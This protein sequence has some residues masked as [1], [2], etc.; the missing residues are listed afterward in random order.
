LFS[1]RQPN[2]N[3]QN[4]RVRE[5]IHAMMN[6]WLEKGISGFRMDVI[7]LIGKVPDEEITANG[8]DLHR[9]LQ[10][11]HEASF[12]NYDIMT[13]GETWGVTPETAR[14]Y[15]DPGRKEL[16]MVF[17]FEHICLTWDPEEGKWR[18]RALDF[19]ALKKSFARWQTVLHGH[20]WNSLFWN[21]HDLPRA[22]SKYGDEGP[23]RVVSAKML[24]TV[25]HGMQGTPYIFQG[26]EI[27]MTNARFEDLAE[28]RDI[29]T[30][31]FYREK[32]EMGHP[33][34][35][36]MKVIQEH[37]RDNAR[38]PMQW[39]AEA[40]AGFTTGEPW[41]PVNRNYTEINVAAALADE[42]SIYHYYKALISLRRHNPVLVHGQFELL[43]PDHPEVFA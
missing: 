39:S 36:L 5:E 22:V 14:L 11:M 24:A 7:D 28:Y 17:Q 43:E 29:E 8:P 23:V 32:S 18:P 2:L 12:G 30:I 35:A 3:W 40:N 13:V 16:S 15:S 38:T 41:I 25:L 10:E 27:G 26:E 6:W 34:G 21:N 19:L 20:G 31:N 42:E 33:H 4:P 1:R 37:G 9:F